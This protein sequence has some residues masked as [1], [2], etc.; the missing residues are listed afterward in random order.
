MPAAVGLR[1]LGSGAAVT[2]AAAAA[3]VVGAA[4]SA[5]GSGTGTS[6]DKVWAA[7]ALRLSV[8]G[9]DPDVIKR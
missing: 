6:S 4:V 7:V 3:E 5:G 9:C 1:M 8:S 2:A